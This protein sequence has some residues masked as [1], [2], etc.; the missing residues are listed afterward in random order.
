[1]RRV[2]VDTMPVGAK[3]ARTVFSSK[4]ESAMQGTN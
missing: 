4:A 2:R 3:L 1:M